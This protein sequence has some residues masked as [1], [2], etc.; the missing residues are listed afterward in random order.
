M[1]L[2]IVHKV[3]KCNFLISHWIL[4]L[5]NKTKSFTCGNL[6]WISGQERKQF[7][8]FQRVVYPFKEGRQLKS[9]AS[10]FE[11]GLLCINI[12]IDFHVML[13]T[14]ICLCVYFIL[15]GI[16]THSSSDS[17]AELSGLLSST[18]GREE[19]KI[20]NSTLPD[21]TEQLP[22]PGGRRPRVKSLEGSD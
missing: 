9:N 11:H 22:K 20:D 10:Q 7:C 19:I 14:T 16:P 18:V 4:F 5:C 12:N 2:N 21:S 17:A 13:M 15:I 8:T 1:F 3:N 6:P